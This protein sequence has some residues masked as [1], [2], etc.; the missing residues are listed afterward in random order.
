M[1]LIDTSPV[2]GAYAVAAWRLA[3][4]SY[5]AALTEGTGAIFP[6]SR[7]FGRGVLERGIHCGTPSTALGVGHM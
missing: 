4:T 2:A 6:V 1:I 3:I 5:L 7:R